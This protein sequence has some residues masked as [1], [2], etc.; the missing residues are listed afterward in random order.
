[1]LL[2][3]EFVKNCVSFLPRLKSWVSALDL[4]EAGRERA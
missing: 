1:M 2:S 3:G 4:Y